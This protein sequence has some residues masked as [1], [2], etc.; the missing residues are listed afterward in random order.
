M[1]SGA[2]LVGNANTDFEAN[3]MESYDAI[4]VNTYSL[5][6]KLLA[7]PPT[8]EL[9]NMLRQIENGGQD[10]EAMAA[11]WGMLKLAA[12]YAT[13]AAADD[14]YHDLFIGIA[15]G[16]LTPYGSWYLTGNMMDRPLVYLRRD[17]ELLGIERQQG[18][19]DPEDHAAA[20][21]EAMA[22]IITDPD[23]LG[24]EVQA[25]FFDQHL[26]PWM[27]QFFGDMQQAEAANFYRAVGRLG[28]QF[29]QMEKR[30][31]DMPE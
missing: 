23:G 24:A 13:V 26:A 18:V 22:V 20:L 15:G 3:A 25:R 10:A 6:A 27:E 4:R 5:L 30:L 19:N 11:T 31:L 12:H 9:L 28:E 7:A 14:E 1:Q 16:E 8:E 21:C 29:M 2:T 17:L